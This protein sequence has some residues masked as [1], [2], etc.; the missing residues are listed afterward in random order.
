MNFTHMFRYVFDKLENILE[1]RENAGNHH[2]LLFVQYF[3]KT[4][5]NGSFN[6][7]YLDFAHLTK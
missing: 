1:K 4:N 7:G 3:Q 2:F 6:G 5:S